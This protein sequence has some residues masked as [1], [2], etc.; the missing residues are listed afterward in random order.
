[1]GPGIPDIGSIWDDGGQLRMLYDNNG[2]WGGKPSA[3]C[4]AESKDGLH[5]TK[6]ELNLVPLGRVFGEQHRAAYRFSRHGDSRSE[7]RH[8]CRGKI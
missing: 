4:L 5:W 6:P 8:A 3:V 1:M 7:S 2:M